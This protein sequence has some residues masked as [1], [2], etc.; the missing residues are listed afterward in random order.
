MT[1]AALLLAALVVSAPAG[2]SAPELVS[3]AA[4][5]R[6]RGELAESLELMRQ[7]YAL[8]PSPVLLNNIGALLESL[9][10]YREAVTA[11]QG[12]LSHPATPPE[13][14]AQDRQRVERLSSKLVAAWLRLESTEE[15]A[16]GWVDGVAVELGAE[17]EVP[18]GAR[19][20]ELWTPRTRELRWLHQR[21]PSG[22]L[23]VV[24]AEAPPD[25]ARL[26]LSQLALPL[27]ALEIDGYRPRGLSRGPQT[28]ALS[29]GRH[30]LRWRLAGEP[31]LERV[32]DLAPGAR[33]G[34]ADDPA[35]LAREAPIGVVA[36][37]APEP[38]SAWPLVVLGGGAALLGAGAALG[39]AAGGDRDLVRSAARDPSG[40][41]I[42]LSYAQ[43]GALEAEANTKA[44]AS[45][46]FFIT[47][48]A[49]VAVGALWW[50]IEHHAL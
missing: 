27:E 34:W 40:V 41:I 17:L 23:T 30:T 38:A 39:L 49:T 6:A 24:R 47:G 12:V 14:I 21:V 2:P 5:L 20:I 1:A 33:H 8:D 44:N 31:P 4:A 36:A 45:A 9:G 29:S 16:E 15:G 35:L 10:R 11:Y 46:A 50:L 37:A 13:L 22:E 25:A 3:R 7:A 42:G 18:A 26:E 19:R 28:I 48:A 32:L 43:A